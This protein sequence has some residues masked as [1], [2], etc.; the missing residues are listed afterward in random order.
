M[1]FG[2]GRVIGKDMGMIGV[3]PKV[4]SEGVADPAS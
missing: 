2:P 4:E 1:N 3:I